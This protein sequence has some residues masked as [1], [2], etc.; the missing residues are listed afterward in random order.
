M[1]IDKMVNIVI[2]KFIR[3]KFNNTDITVENFD[4]KTVN[5]D[6][7][8]KANTTITVSKRELLSMFINGLD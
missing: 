3:K 1:N 8:I 6:V 7:V 2:N 4:V 5:D